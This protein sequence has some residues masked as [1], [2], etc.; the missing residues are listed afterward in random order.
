M[1]LDLDDTILATSDAERRS[2][3]ELCERFNDRL[4]GHAPETGYRAI[5]EYRDWYDSEP[6]RAQL[7]MLGLGDYTWA[8]TLRI[9]LDRLRLPDGAEALADE[10]AAEYQLF[11]DR[12]P[13]LM[14]GAIETLR[15]LRSHGVRLVLLTAGARQ[16]HYL[17]QH[18]LE[19]FFDSILIASEIG[20]GKPRPEVYHHALTDLRARPDEAWMVGD[21]L[22]NDVAAPQQ[23]GIHGVWLDV[24][25]TGVPAEISVRPDR[26]IRSLAELV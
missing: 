6:A 16:R 25:G 18:A 24:L 21:N 11:R 10:L 17:A 9:V 3:L 19:P 15:R 23:L 22:Q 2:W 13:A 1:L 26:I 8:S 7:S 12:A 20:Y 4:G 5:Q 14:P